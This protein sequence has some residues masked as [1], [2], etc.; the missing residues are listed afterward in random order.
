MTI[1]PK[2]CATHHLDGVVAHV[3]RALEVHADD[4]VE[5]VL[6]HV[7]DHALAQHAGRVDDE[8]DLAERLGA[9]AHHATGAW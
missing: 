6:G 4:G 1:R 7:P 8:V 3:P 9:L 2:R 5:V